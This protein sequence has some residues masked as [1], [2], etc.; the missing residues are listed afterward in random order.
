[1]LPRNSQRRVHQEGAPAA[2]PEMKPLLQPHGAS[3]GGQ[4]G[5]QMLEPADN[6]SIS[7]G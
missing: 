5:G 4:S 6:L 1:M 7:P 3:S 2:F